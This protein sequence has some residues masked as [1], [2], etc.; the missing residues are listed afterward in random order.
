MLDQFGPD[1]ALHINV[2]THITPFCDCWGM[3]TPAMVPD[4]G[5]MGSKDIVAVEQASLD[6][7]DASKVIPGSIPAPLKLGKGRHLF[8]KL[9]ARDP[10]LQVGFLEKLGSGTSKYRLEEIR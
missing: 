5:I 10:Y 1:R 7:I 4:I 6:S 8:E 9:H 2:L 3:T